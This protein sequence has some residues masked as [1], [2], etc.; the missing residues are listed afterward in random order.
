[1]N[2]L[3]KNLMDNVGWYAN[4]NA[5]EISLN[6]DGSELRIECFIK[7]STVTK[8]ILGSPSLELGQPSF[9]IL[10][11]K[12]SELTQKYKGSLV[13]EKWVI[14]FIEANSRSRYRLTWQQAL[15]N[16]QGKSPYKNYGYRKTYANRVSELTNL[17]VNGDFRDQFL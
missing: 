8:L 7:N 6:D 14:G 16:Q 11:H 1:M 15:S 13:H 3:L 17:S 12:H 4:S 9:Q 5:L 2:E 10:Q